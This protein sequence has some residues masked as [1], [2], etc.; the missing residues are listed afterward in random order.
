MA[1]RLF[2]KRKKETM[3]AVTTVIICIILIVATTSIGIIIL[4]ACIRF[5]TFGLLRGK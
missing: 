2:L 3:G 5:T 1:S 4:K